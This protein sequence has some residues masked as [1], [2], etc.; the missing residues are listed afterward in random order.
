MFYDSDL[1]MSELSAATSI[2]LSPDELLCLRLTLNLYG[3]EHC[4]FGKVEAVEADRLEVATR[5]LV[6][7]G[8]VDKKGYRPDRDLTRRL[9]VVSE[10]D[11]RVVLLAATPTSAERLLDAYQRTGVF[12]QHSHPGA[13]HQLGPV[14]EPAEI[15][16][17]LSRRFTP[18][19]STGDFIDLHLSGPEHFVFMC[20]AQELAL[21][22]D[23]PA[24]L[25]GEVPVGPVDRTGA[26]LLPG[27]KRR[28]ARDEPTLG[29]LPVPSEPQWKA[30]LVALEAMDVVRKMKDGF[31]LKPYLRDLAVGL[32]HKTRYILTRFD[33][34]PDDWVVRDATFVPV[35]GSLF[36]CRPLEQG[37]LRIHELDARGL[38]RTLHE[39]VDG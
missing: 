19:R 39:V 35:P 30:A 12:V 32:V 28:L 25:T 21:G 9:L 24:V 1:R 2:P 22:A 31:H 15:F 3:D 16:E 27:K 11:A 38:E 8:L 13:Q 10:P 5:G 26:I 18:R 34:Q 29:R 37:G 20:F 23:R 4:A 33:Y 17:A 14:L 6:Q 7:R 36:S